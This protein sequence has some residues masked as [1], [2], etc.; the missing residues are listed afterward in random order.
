MSAATDKAKEATA[1]AVDKPAADAKAAVEE[2]KPKPKKAAI[3]GC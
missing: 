1:E 2:V 3:E